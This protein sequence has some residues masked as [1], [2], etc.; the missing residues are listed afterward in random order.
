MYIKIKKIYIRV[1]V[2]HY[3][4]NCSTLQF[5][6]GEAGD[7]DKLYSLDDTARMRIKKEM[8]TWIS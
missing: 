7:S 8:Y 6:L 5:M 2:I 1:T 4:Y 3:R